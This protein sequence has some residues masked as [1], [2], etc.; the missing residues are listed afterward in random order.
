MNIYYAITPAFANVT[1]FV[2]EGRHD[3]VYDRIMF[4]TNN[5][6]LAAEVSSWSE[7]ALVGEV[8]E[9]DEFIVA[10]IEDDE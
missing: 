1:R 4:I 10:V 7:N 9:T 8:Y 6:E 3:L 2:Q 5:H